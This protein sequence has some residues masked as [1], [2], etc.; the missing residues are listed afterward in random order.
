MRVY[1]CMCV[2]L[3]I[4]TSWTNIIACSPEKRKNIA[5]VYSQ[6][7]H[8]P[9]RRTVRFFVVRFPASRS[10]RSANMGRL[11]VCVSLVTITPT[12][13][14]RFIW[15]STINDGSYQFINI[16]GTARSGHCYGPASHL[17]DEARA[18]SPCRWRIAVAPLLAADSTLMSLSLLS[19][20]V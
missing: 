2:Y 3:N 19:P 20:L 4:T 8:K 1:V 9:S 14:T 7:G 11:A 17:V 18:R 15:P 6:T 5:S 12:P 16:R 10:S 13:C